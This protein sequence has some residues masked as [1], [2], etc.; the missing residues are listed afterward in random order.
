[1]SIDDKIRDQL[2]RE[3]A[4]LRAQ[5]KQDPSLFGMLADAYKGRLGGWMVLMTLIA[6]LLTAIIVWSGYE[7]F[8]VES[9]MAAKLHWGIGLLL[10]TMMQIAIKMWTFNEMNRSATQRELKKLELAIQ[11]LNQRLGDKTK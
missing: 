11:Q 4:L 6:L 8:F 9:S 2:E 7:F 5:I 1:M 10:A 3:N